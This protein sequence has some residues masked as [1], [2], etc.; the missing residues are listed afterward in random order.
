MAVN[1]VSPSQTNKNLGQ[2]QD[3]NNVH[4]GV[5]WVTKTMYKS[6]EPLESNMMDAILRDDVK[7]VKQILVNNHFKVEKFLTQTQLLQL[8]Q[9]E[10]KARC[11]KLF[12][13]KMKKENKKESKPFVLMD[14]N[15]L[16]EYLLGDSNLQFQCYH[17]QNDNSANTESEQAD[18]QEHKISDEPYLHLFIWSVLNN[19]QDMAKL[20]WRQGKDAIA[21]ALLADALLFAMSRHSDDRDFKAQCE[22]N[23]REFTNLAIGVLKE[24]HEQNANNAKDLLLRKSQWGETS[25][26]LLAMNAKNKQFISEHACQD[27]FNNIWMGQIAEDNSSLTDNIKLLLCILIPPL[28]LFDRCIT[29]I[30]MKEDEQVSANQGTPVNV[31]SRPNSRQ[32]HPREKNNASVIS[33]Q[34]QEIKSCLSKGQRITSFYEAPV[35]IFFHNVISY[36]IF[37]GLYS[38]ILIS[39]FDRYL[40]WEEI[41]L[42]VWVFTIFTQEVIQVYNLAYFFMILLVFIVAY[43]IASYAILYPHTEPSLETLTEIFRRPYWNIYGELMLDTI[44]DSVDCTNNPELYKNGTYS[45]CPTESGKYFVPLLMGVYMLMCNILLLNLLIAMFSFT[46]QKD[47]DNSYLYWRFQQCSLINEYANRP[48]LAPPLIIF[49]HLSYLIRRVARCQLKCGDVNQAGQNVLL[50]PVKNCGMLRDWEDEIA[51]KFYKF[52]QEQHY[53]TGSEADSPN[54]EKRIENIEKQL[55]WIVTTMRETNRGAKL[56]S[57]SHVTDTEV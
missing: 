49:V 21:A 50:K 5:P 43:G 46:F 11:F 55:N 42:C 13:T 32:P 36:M 47:Q 30:Q 22:K 16:L 45:R 31:Q 12:L 54:L 53:S 35:I 26:V 18:R 38:Y 57:V 51:K 37:L 2:D 41:L 7:V 33:Q 25:C 14:V 44:D 6:V 10:N 1:K 3:S 28:I 39:K 19:Q 8:Y 24:C 48:F 4:K 27:I 23:R 17:I 40:S 52:E 34:T 29:F 56:D 15:E 9:K 20:F